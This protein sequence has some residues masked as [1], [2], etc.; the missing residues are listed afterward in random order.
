M[1]AAID[2]MQIEPRIF[3]EW[4]FRAHIGGIAPGDRELGEA[5][6]DFGERLRASVRRA[7]ERVYDSQIPSA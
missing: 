4:R 7:E 6:P 3:A 2:E 1:A 5:L